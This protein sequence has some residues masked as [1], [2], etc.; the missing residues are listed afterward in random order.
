MGWFEHFCCFHVMKWL[1]YEHF[2]YC[3]Y[4][5]AAISCN[6]MALVWAFF[7][8]GYKFVIVSYLQAVSCCIGDTVVEHWIVVHSFFWFA[9]LFFFFISSTHEIIANKLMLLRLF[10]LFC[11]SSLAGGLKLKGALTLVCFVLSLFTLSFQLLLLLLLTFFHLLFY[12]VQGC[13]LLTIIK[14]ELNPFLQSFHGQVIRVWHSNLENLIA[15]LSDT[16]H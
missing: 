6:E 1:E 2:C 8:N 3:I 11:V 15:Y 4:Y 9:Y 5:I 10:H 14:P 12:T 13:P 7:Y 16:S